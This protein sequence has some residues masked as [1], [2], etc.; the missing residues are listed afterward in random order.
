MNVEDIC[1]EVR[2]LPRPKQGELICRLLEEF[3]TSNY[4]VSDAEVAERVAEMASGAIS[5][6][7]HDQLLSEL[8]HFRRS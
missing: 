4:D 7:S 5:D 3:G 8:D 1:S 6:I 2:Q